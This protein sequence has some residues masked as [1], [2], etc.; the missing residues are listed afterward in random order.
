MSFMSAA[1]S[2]FWV[3]ISMILCGAVCTFSGIGL[4][5]SLMR[6]NW[7]WSSHIEDQLL[8]S[9]EWAVFLG[10]RVRKQ[11]A[12][13]TLGASAFRTQFPWWLLL[14]CSFQRR[15]CVSYLLYQQCL[16]WIS[17]SSSIQSQSFCPCL[18]AQCATL[19]AHSLW[20]QSIPSVEWSDG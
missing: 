3:C 19:P 16:S 5:P 6:F 14:A 10:Y 4:I 18:N 2:S 11:P 12:H 9:D 15:N 1:I 13:I 17:Q 8:L 7:S 20:H